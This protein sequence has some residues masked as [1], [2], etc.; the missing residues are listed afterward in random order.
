M[1]HKLKQRLAE[2]DMK[3]F[4]VLDEHFCLHKRQLFL[5]SDKVRKK[6]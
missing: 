1:F 5:L 2:K 6:G 4:S 3:E